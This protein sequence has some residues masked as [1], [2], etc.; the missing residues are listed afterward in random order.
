VP[1][2]GSIKP[3]AR[4]AASF[5]RLGP[6]KQIDMAEQTTCGEGLAAHSALPAVLGELTSAIADVLEIHTT[7]LD[8]TDVNAQSERDVYVKLVA[9]HRQT[10]AEL[11][12]T[13]EGMSGQRDL[14]M[15]RHDP[16][17]MS[18]PAVVDAFERLIA[19]EERLLTLL[20]DRL[21]HDRELLGE[22]R[23]AA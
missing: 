1:V 3:G 20:Q 11:G 10:A 16:K 9:E 12:S 15:A 2:P 4:R 23:R 22:I 17:V 14:P 13:A 6:R 19:V 18:S 5:E 8:L 7:A 21:R